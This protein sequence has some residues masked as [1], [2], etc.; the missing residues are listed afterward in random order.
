M[1]SDL[2][3]P[4]IFSSWKIQEITFCASNSEV[5]Q[6]FELYATFYCNAKT[7][8]NMLMSLLYGRNITI[9][10]PW[11]LGMFWKFL[12]GAISNISSIIP[13]PMADFC[14][15]NFKIDLSM[16]INLTMNFQIFCCFV[17]IKFKVKNKIQIWT[18][19]PELK[20]VRLVQATYRNARAVVRTPY[21][22]KRNSRLMLDYIKDLH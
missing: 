11:F 6:K 14:L 2:K 17:S 19:W 18:D 15:V 10:Y 21:E 12:K 8:W 7:R 4:A 1:G 5:S 9:V 13:E 20:L 16:P 22:Q 3:A